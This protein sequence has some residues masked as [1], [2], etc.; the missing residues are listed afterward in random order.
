MKW[1]AD[2]LQKLRGMFA[3]AIWDAETKH[4]FCAKDRFGIKPFYYSIVDGV[5]YF[6]SEVKALLKFQKR[7]HYQQKAC[8]IILFTNFI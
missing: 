2:C 4:L 5:F 8:L 3:F 1:G 7:F 6:A